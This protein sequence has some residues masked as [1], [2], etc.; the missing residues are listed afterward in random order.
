MFDERVEREYQ[1]K[2]LIAAKLDALLNEFKISE[3]D[4]SARL[5]LYLDI[6]LDILRCCYD[7]SINYYREYFQ[8]VERYLVG[9]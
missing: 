3:E 4:I 7:T 2:Q 9:Y 8:R 5:G 6:L 1:E